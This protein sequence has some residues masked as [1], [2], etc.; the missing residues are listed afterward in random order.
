MIVCNCCGKKFRDESCL[1]LCVLTDN[2]D[3]TSSA[4]LY[5]G[6]D[7]DEEHSELIKGCP[8]CLTDEYLMDKPS[9]YKR[10]YRRGGKILSLDELAKQEFVYWHDKVEPRGWFLSWQL[11]MALDNMGESGCIYYAIV[12]D[13]GASIWKER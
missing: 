10:K 12:E 2:G 6:E 4:K 3:G 8:N 13:K 11:K 7:Y 5:A 9:R 1:T